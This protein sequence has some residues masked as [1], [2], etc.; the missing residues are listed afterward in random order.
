MRISDISRLAWE[1]VKR[2]KVVTGLCMAGISI[3][4]AAIIVALSIGDS[5]QSYTEREINRNFKMDEITVSPNGGIPSQGGGSGGSGSSAANEK[6]DPGRLTAQK[7]EIIKGL[8]HVTAAA[9]FQELGYI[10][11]LTIDNKITDVQLIGTDLRLLTKYDKK[12]KQGGASDLVGMAVLNYGATV[13]LI[14][15][16]TRQRLF[17][18]LSTDPYNNKLME[19]YNSLSMLPTDMYK[20]Q[21]QLQSFDP[22]S[23]TGG[24]LVSSPIQVVGILDNPSG[25]NENMAMYDKKIYVSLETGERLVEQMKLSSGTAGQKGVYNSAIVKVDS[26]ENIV[27]LEKLIQKL[28]LTTST[29]LYQKEALADT[30]SM[31]KKA[32]LGVGVFIL[33]IASISIIVAMTM[34]T[35]QRRRQIGIMKVLGANMGQIRNM[36][37]TEAAL[38]GMLGGLLGIV[39]SYLIVLGIN[40]LIGT[41]SGMGGGEPLVIYIPLMTLPVGIAFAVMTGVLSGIYPAISASRTNAL[42]AIKRD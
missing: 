21:V 14:D 16:E 31:V 9:P 13:G 37:I 34:S 3:G 28:T 27:E 20:Q 42:T 32:A 15:N 38:L 41:S 10:Q 1:Q 2:R 40:K 19:Q 23:Q 18:Q 25:T 4:C 6:L 7:L 17:E 39:F 36:F 8:R 24:M 26:T 33:I 5:A 30:F 12:F 35:H 22:A 29:N 11:M